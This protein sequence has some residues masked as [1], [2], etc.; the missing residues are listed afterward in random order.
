MGKDDKDVIVIE[1]D[2]DDMLGPDVP[3]DDGWTDGDAHE[4][5]TRFKALLEDLDRLR[6]D[7]TVVE[8]M[9]IE[10]LERLTR[11]DSDA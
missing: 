7:D 9:S 3:A 8:H 10:E 1:L 6:D 11:N 4:E 2:T 5:V